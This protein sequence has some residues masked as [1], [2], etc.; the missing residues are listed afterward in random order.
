MSTTDMTE[1]EAQGTGVPRT[2]AE[3]TQDAIAAS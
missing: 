1:A 2:S 3:R